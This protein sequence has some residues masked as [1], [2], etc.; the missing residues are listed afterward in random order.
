MTYKS[1]RRR[2]S[3]AVVEEY[4]CGTTVSCLLCSQVVNQLMHEA[5]QL[6][7]YCAG[8]FAVRKPAFTVLNDGYFALIAA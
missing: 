8:C 2:V 4:S 3:C 1:C 6:M 7:A 5:R